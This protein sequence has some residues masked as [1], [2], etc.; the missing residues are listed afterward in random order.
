MSAFAS[1]GHEYMRGYA[2]VVCA[3]SRGATKREEIVFRKTEIERAKIK[4]SR[5]RKIEIFRKY[6]V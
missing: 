4:R 5:K 1:Y 3:M 6:C 2:H